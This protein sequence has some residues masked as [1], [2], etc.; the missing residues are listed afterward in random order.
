MPT[1]VALPTELEQLVAE[2]IESGK[3]ASP[4][5]VIQE[6]LRLLKERDE[7]QS[8]L[9]ELREEIHAG[10]Q[11][12]ER[13]QFTTYDEASLPRLIEEVQTEGRSKRDQKSAD[14]HG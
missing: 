10:L 5:E 7:Q 14:F 3:Y 9:E 4:S 12:L 13:G 1:K 11:Q 8:R 2:R 6:A